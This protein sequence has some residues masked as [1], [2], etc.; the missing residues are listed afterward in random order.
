MESNAINAVERKERKRESGESGSVQIKPSITHGVIKL[1]LLEWM[2]SAAM[3]TAKYETKCY[4]ILL[5]VPRVALPF[6][7]VGKT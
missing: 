3:P 5:N 6:R 1:S 2:T 4:E 7:N